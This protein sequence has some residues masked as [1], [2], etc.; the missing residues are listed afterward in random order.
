MSTVKLV[1]PSAIY[2]VIKILMKY[3]ESHACCT[4]LSMLEE[5]GNKLSIPLVEA[6]VNND[7]ETAIR[8]LEVEIL[9]CEREEEK[10]I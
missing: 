6:V 9:E 1:R 2:K 10:I 8:L 5:Q 4:L 3:N 7:R